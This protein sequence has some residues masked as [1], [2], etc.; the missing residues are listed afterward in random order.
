MDRCK[1]MII[2]TLVRLE[3]DWKCILS[4]MMWL[5]WL[6]LYEM[7]QGVLETLPMSKNR[8]IIHLKRRERYRRE[9][10]GKGKKNGTKLMSG[11]SHTLHLLLDELC[12]EVEDTLGWD[13]I[14]V[15]QTNPARIKVILGSSLTLSC[16]KLHQCIL[17]TPQS[18]WTV[19]FRNLHIQETFLLLASSHRSA[20][21]VNLSSVHQTHAG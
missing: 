10:A 2:C 6:D 20:W 17:M 19:S 16:F 5:W 4:I 1:N 13:Y 9:E 3:L 12:L 15:G 21:F 14:F 7:P 11:V 18:L 8:W